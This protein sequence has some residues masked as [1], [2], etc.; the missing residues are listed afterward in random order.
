MIKSF[1]HKGL[2]KFFYDGAKTGIQAKH[3]QKLGDIL[4]MLDAAANVADMN[5]PGARLHPWEPKEANI[6]S[7][8]VSGQWRVV[9]RFKDGNALEVDYVQPH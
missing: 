8:D 7:V 6:W 3:A 4:D 2:E 5:F 1:K 9:F